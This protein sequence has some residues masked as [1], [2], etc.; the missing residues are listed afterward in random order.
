MK[1]VDIMSKPM[2]HLHYKA[3]VG[4]VIVLQ[5]AL[6]FPITEQ[7]IKSQLKASTELKPIHSKQFA[8]DVYERN[9]NVLNK[10][11]M[12]LPV[13]CVSLKQHSINI[14]SKQIIM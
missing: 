5:K 14:T 1:L 9:P 10:Q 8:L 4:I 6:Q 12:D 2:K 13:Y 3:M 11:L 7:D